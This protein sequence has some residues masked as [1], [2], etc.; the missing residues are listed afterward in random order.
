MKT[1]RAISANRKPIKAQGDNQQIEK[2]VAGSSQRK[3]NNKLG[4][5]MSQGNSLRD[6]L[7]GSAPDSHHPGTI[8]SNQGH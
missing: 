3:H 6:G 2:D 1:S 7:F 4:S 5:L 8:S